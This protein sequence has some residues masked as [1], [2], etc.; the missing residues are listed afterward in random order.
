[1]PGLGADVRYML[2]EKY[3]VGIDFA[4]GK[5]SDAWYFVVGEVF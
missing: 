3:R 2:T 5:D 4:R 1:V